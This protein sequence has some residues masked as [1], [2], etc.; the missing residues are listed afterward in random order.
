VQVGSSTPAYEK[1]VRRVCDK[2]GIARRRNPLTPQFETH[3]PWPIRIA[4]RSQ[5]RLALRTK[6]KPEFEPFMEYI[7]LG[8]TGWSVLAAAW[9]WL[10]RNKRSLTSFSPSNETIGLAE[11]ATPCARQLQRQC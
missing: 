10:R 8:K 5:E 2:R 7:G 1:A 3:V 4:P 9:R 11:G 6:W